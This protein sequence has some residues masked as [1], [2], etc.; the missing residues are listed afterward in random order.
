MGQAPAKGNQLVS[1]LPDPRAALEAL[2]QLIDSC[3]RGEARIVRFNITVNS[4]GETRDVRT[5][6]G[7]LQKIMVAPPTIDFD[8]QVEDQP[9]YT[10][11][12]EYS[13][14]AEGPRN[15][16]AVEDTSGRRT[17]VPCQ[18]YKDLIARIANTVTCI[19]S[20]DLDV[21]EIDMP[22][23]AWSRIRT[24]LPK[25]VADSSPTAILGT[26]VNIRPPATAR[27][28]PRELAELDARTNQARFE[29]RQQEQRD[30]EKKRTAEQRAKAA[31][32]AE[33]RA[34]GARDLI[35]D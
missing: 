33:S 29:A 3:E 5:I 28:S 34:K 18:P 10:R 12:S 24:D 21:T 22:N 6:N 17:R 13:G 26:M 23:E 32:D 19:R 16:V 30:A 31:R 14:V 4:T 11:P 9:T 1:D 7:T 35:F 8:L 20:Q 15:Y 2:R 25:S 27:P